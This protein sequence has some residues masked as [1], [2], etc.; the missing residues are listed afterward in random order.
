MDMIVIRPYQAEDLIAMTAL[1]LDLGYPTTAEQMRSRMGIIET[2]P[3]SYTYLAALEGKVV[4]MIGIRQIYS[5]EE[6]GFVTQI[7]LLVTK[8]EYEFQ[9]IGTS[10]VRFAEAWALERHSGM[11]YLTSGMKPERIRAH[12]F[13]KS[14]GFETTG[15]RFVKKLTIPQ[16]Y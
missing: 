5:Y 3:G 12:K 16:S 4:G 7:S 8:K 15:Y 1:M 14:L 6:D 13:Y 2:L 11:L 10:L 9:G